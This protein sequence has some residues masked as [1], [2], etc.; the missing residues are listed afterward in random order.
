[1]RC[2]TGIFYVAQ[3]NFKYQWAP[4][5]SER[6]FRPLGK[7]D[8]SSHRLNPHANGVLT[9]NGTN[10]P[11]PESQFELLRR[12]NKRIAKR[13]LPNGLVVEETQ[14]FP[15]CNA[16]EAAPIRA[17]AKECTVRPAQELKLS[18]V[19]SLLSPTVAADGDVL[20][21]LE[22][23]D[24]SSLAARLDAER[25]DAQGVG[26]SQQVDRGDQSSMR[27]SPIKKLA[28]GRRPKAK[29]RALSKSTRTK[30]V[31]TC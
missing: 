1:M 28:P 3:H 8:C 17:G 5:Q 18:S 19:I 11:M 6:I 25:H 29:A 21:R 24:A 23:A 26:T 20:E 4:I 9:P 16:N 22:H 7:E 30:P 2:R 15:D 14:L 31:P 12:T 27:E 13:R 10:A